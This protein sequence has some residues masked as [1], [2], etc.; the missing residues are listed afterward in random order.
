MNSLPALPSFSLS[1]L[2]GPFYLRGPQLI[3]VGL[4]FAGT[5]FVIVMSCVWLE[6][7]KLKRL[8]VQIGKEF[9]RNQNSLHEGARREI[10]PALKELPYVYQ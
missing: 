1:Y 3:A 5:L 7:K 10:E 2:V 8:E 6:W 9:A 4:A